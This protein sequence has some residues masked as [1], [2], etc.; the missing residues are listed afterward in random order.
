MSMTCTTSLPRFSSRR[1]TSHA[2]YQSPLSRC[3]SKKNLKRSSHRNQQYSITA[4]TDGSGVVIE[5]YAY[6]A[7][8]TP[9]ITDASG[10]P[11]TTTAIGNRYTYTGREWDQDLALYHCRA[12]MYD[13]VG[14]RFVSR[15]PTGLEGSRYGLYGFL[16]GYALSAVDPY[17]LETGVASP[18]GPRVPTHHSFPRGPRYPTVIPNTTPST[19]VGT[20]RL[21]AYKIPHIAVFCVGVGTGYCIAENRNLEK[22]YIDVTYWVCDSEHG[23]LPIPDLDRNPHE[24]DPNEEERERRRECEERAERDWRAREES[25]KGKRTR[26]QVKRC[27]DDA[28]QDY[29]D[30]LADCVKK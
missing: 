19:T 10:T 8:G 25:C 11:R 23:P 18:T 30:D 16:A 7:Y 24:P 3:R 26:E 12:R 9:T 27:L 29:A 13:P 28:F 6:S 4:I 17:G 15:D 21:V 22:K 14:G 5:R 1:L 20:C 2:R